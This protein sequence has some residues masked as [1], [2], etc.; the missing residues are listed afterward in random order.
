MTELADEGAADALFL[1]IHPGRRFC[2]LHRPSRRH[3]VKG[4]V[5]C[6]HPFAEELNKTRRMV[7]VG[8]RALAQ[9]GWAVMQIDLFGCGDSSGEFKDAEWHQWLTDLTAAERWLME[10]YEAPFWLWGIRA[11]CLLATDV[12]TA[13]TGT[14]NLLLWQP[15]YSGRQHLTQFLRVQVANEML[16]GNAERLGT[17]ALRAKLLSGSSVEIAGYELSPAMARALHK[18]DFVVPPNYRQA[19]V[20]LEVSA[21]EV[22]ALSPAS[23]VRIERLEEQGCRFKFTV[24][25]GSPFWQTVEITECQALIEA[26]QLLLSQQST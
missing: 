19:I 22:P 9:D 10:Q 13:M 17:E 16:G 11:G 25:R 6:V 1:P 8:S 24:V 2:I 14:P 20:L 4:T 23:A 5:L 21:D 3:K 18:A 15:V 26:T 7:A 12:L